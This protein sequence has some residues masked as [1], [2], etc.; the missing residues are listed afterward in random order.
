MN[1]DDTYT[2]CT[3]CGRPMAYCKGECG[4]K[5]KGCGCKEYGP[6]VCG[7]IRQTEP[8]CPHVA[9][10]PSVVVEHADSLKDLCDTFVHVS[11]LNTTFYIDDK[12]RPIITWA[13]PV[14][15]DN[16]DLA[17][18]SLGLRSQFMI[19]FA[20]NRGAYYDKTG[21]YKIFNFGSS[22]EVKTL[23]VIYTG[24]EYPENW[25]DVDAVNGVTRYMITDVTFA[26]GDSSYTPEDVYSMLES[27]TKVILN[28]VPL[29]AYITSGNVLRAAT[30]V[31][32]VELN[33][34]V[35][36]MYSD[37]SASIISYT[38]AAFARATDANITRCFGVQLERSTDGS[39][40]SFYVEGVGA[41]Q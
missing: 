7:A 30:T 10:I 27:G 14:E 40:Y 31:D 24:G 23:E 3:N 36:D 5:P 32:G 17:T 29:G 11:D 38:G 26:D 33:T 39:L 35:T 13:G 28:G 21:N 18:N 34:K 9:V 25:D 20:N 41:G 16:Y 19:D 1:N 2:P 22:A 15:Y 8:K 4:C 37:A 6:A 12:H